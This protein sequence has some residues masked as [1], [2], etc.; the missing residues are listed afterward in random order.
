MSLDCLT[1]QYTGARVSKRY[2]Q[3]YTESFTNNQRMHKQWIPGP[4][5]EGLGTRLLCYCTLK[6]PWTSLHYPRMTHCQYT[7]YLHV[8]VSMYSKVKLDIH[9]ISKDDLLPLHLPVKVSMYTSYIGHPRTFRGCP[10]ANAP[11]CQ[12]IHVHQS[13]IGRPQTF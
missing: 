12:S 8:K 7:M 11:P 10:T 6:L 1:S 13:Y 9:G 3:Y 4:S 5:R 2:P